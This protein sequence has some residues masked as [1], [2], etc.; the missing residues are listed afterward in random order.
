MNLVRR[1]HILV[2]G[3]L[4]LGSFGAREMNAQEVLVTRRDDGVVIQNGILKRAVSAGA[5]IP[6]PVSAHE[7]TLIQSR[8]PLL[9][10][11]SQSPWFYFHVNGSRVT[12]RDPA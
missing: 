8:S 1:S 10:A 2:A 3:L 9:D 11:T 4:L 12:S 5:R 6:A 7:I